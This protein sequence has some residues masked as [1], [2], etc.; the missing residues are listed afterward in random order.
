MYSGPDAIAYFVRET[1]R[2]TWFT[3]VPVVLA[4]AS[5]QPAF[6]QEF[7][8]SVSRAG[9]YLINTFL[10]VHIPEVTLATGNQFTTAGRLRWTKNL[11]HNL[12]REC[13]ISFNDLIAARFDA[14][15]LDF[16]SAFT[17]AAGKR[18]GYN[19]M[20]GYTADLIQPHA[21]GVKIPETIINLPLPFWFSRDSGLA[22]PTASLPYN[23]IRLQFN[24]R[25]WKDLLILD[26]T[27]YDP[28]KNPNTL[29]S[30]TP[31]VSDLVGGEPSLGNCQIFAT[32]AIVSN[33]E[34]RRMGCTPRDCLVEQVQTAPIQNF[35]PATNSSPTYDIRFSHAIKVLFFAVRNI[36]IHS[37]HSNY[38]AATPVIVTDTSVTPNVSVVNFSPSGADDPIKH[39]SLIYENT[40][41]LSNMGSDYFSLVNPWYT[42]PTIPIETGYHC[43][44]YALDF[45]S[46]DPCGS[47]NFGKLTNVSI[48]PEASDGAVNGANG[49]SSNAVS[50]GIS[51]PQK[52]HFIVIA[53]NYNVI[54]ISGGALGLTYRIDIWKSETVGCRTSCALT[55]MDK[56][57]NMR[58][59]AACA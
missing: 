6:G 2:S 46:L 56:Q 39:T 35:S 22:L 49:N 30:V 28:V 45:Y 25:D 19:N 16:W 31:L 1:V 27:A 12:I 33:E 52:Y 24:F 17:V 53:V 58:Y 9:D 18:V 38:T 8:V 54:R 26:N 41:R 21:P 15:F 13:A 3:T 4:R 40:P 51:F 55:G 5:G 20:I 36:S 34:R 44:S 50:T 43:Y 14:Y 23:E 57:C 48:A 11:A 42:A 29:P 47:T 10:R 37:Q 7:S 32:Y 59:V